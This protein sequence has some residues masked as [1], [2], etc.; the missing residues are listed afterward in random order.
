MDHWDSP[1]ISARSPGRRPESAMGSLAIFPSLFSTLF[2]NPIHLILPAPRQKTAACSSSNGRP[3][4]WSSQLATSSANEHNDPGLTV[5]YR[6]H[7]D[8]HGLAQAR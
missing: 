4:I 5:P 1:P 3:H 6:H 7:G 2:P 8:C